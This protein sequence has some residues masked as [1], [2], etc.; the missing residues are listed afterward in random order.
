M[1]FY[2]HHY[3]VN[4]FFTV[5]VEKQKWRKNCKYYYATEICANLGYEREMLDLNS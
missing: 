3:R 1:L 4:I 2:F 5:Q